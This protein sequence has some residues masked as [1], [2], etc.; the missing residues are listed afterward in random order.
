MMQETKDAHDDEENVEDSRDDVKPLVKFDTVQQV[1]KDYIMDPATMNPGDLLGVASIMEPAIETGLIES[2]RGGGGDAKKHVGCQS[3]DGSGTGSQ[4]SEPSIKGQETDP[5]EDLD[6]KCDIT[7]SQ[8]SEV[9]QESERGFSGFD[10]NEEF[11]SEEKPECSLSGTH[12]NSK[13]RS[14]CLDIDL[15]VADD[16]EDKDVIVSG[17]P[18]GEESSVDASPW[19]PTMLHLDLNRCQSASQSCSSSSSSKESSMKNFDLNFG[20]NNAASWD[21]QNAVISLFGTQVEVNQRDNG[22]NHNGRILEPAS[23]AS[24]G[25]GSFAPGPSMYYYSS[26][27]RPPGAL[28]PYMVDPR[29]VPIAPQFAPP[30]AMN[31]A[32]SLYFA[33]TGAGPLQQNMGFNLGIPMSG[34]NSGGSSSSVVGKRQEPD[35]GW[36]A[37]PLNYKHLPP[38]WK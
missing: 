34:G 3:E 35:G 36:E 31:M 22:P 16:N 19:K 33:P 11:C 13:Q 37:F 27:Y 38:P 1:D 21:H 14:T 7:T 23:K 9:A 8:V 15:N 25:Q 30:F 18:S 20:L 6:Q 4:F 10:L 26:P 12:S 24:W 2:E 28:S 17:L 5:I 32:G 29:G